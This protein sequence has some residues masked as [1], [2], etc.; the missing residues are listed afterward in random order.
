MDG[1][2]GLCGEKRRFLEKL[3][4]AKPVCYIVLNSTLGFGVKLQVCFLKFYNINSTSVVASE[5]SSVKNMPSITPKK[6]ISK[7]KF[8]CSYLF[9]LT[10][11]S[12]FTF[13]VAVLIE[14]LMVCFQN[15][16]MKKMCF[17]KRDEMSIF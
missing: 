7:T 16:T 9:V 1:G 8:Y 11:T 12:Y 3:L 15:C 5:T 13:I 14:V 4:Y 2:K 6:Y 10:E 17:S